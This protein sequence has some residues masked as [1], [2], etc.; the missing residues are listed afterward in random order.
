MEF[1]HRVRVE[2]LAGRLL[3]AFYSSFRWTPTFSVL[4]GFAGL[5]SNTFSVLLEIAIDA[6]RDVP[7]TLHHNL[8][9]PS[10]TLALFSSTLALPP[11][12]L[13][14]SST[15]KRLQP[16]SVFTASSSRTISSPADPGDAPIVERMT[17]K[18]LSK[19]SPANA[20][21]WKQ[22]SIDAIMEAAEVN[23]K[24]SIKKYMNKRA[25]VAGP[26][27]TSSTNKSEKKVKAEVTP[28]KRNGMTADHAI[29]CLQPVGV[30]FAQVKCARAQIQSRHPLMP[31][32]CA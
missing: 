4:L 21:A 10:F 3:L 20:A 30:G 2:F 17:R 13:P 6:A 28:S 9:A 19:L 8:G 25:D 16:R 27:G 26:S 12:M 15:G 1:T 24:D 5:L 31:L 23:D 32:Q 18:R 29:L 11:V 14:N 7:A 22:S